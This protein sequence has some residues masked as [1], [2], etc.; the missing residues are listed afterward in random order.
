MDIISILPHADALHVLLVVPVALV[1]RFAHDVIIMRTPMLMASAKLVI[2]Q[3]KT[4]LVVCSKAP[5][6]GAITAFKGKDL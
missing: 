1:R 6:F 4:A 5:L 2:Q 3:L